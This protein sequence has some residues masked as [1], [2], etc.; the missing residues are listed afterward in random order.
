M[1]SRVG[2]IQSNLRSSCLAQTWMSRTTRTDCHTLATSPSCCLPKG[3]VEK[4]LHCTRLQ[5][6]S[7]H[8][9]RRFACLRRV[10]ATMPD[11]PNRNRCFKAVEVIRT[12]GLR[13]SLVPRARVG[14]RLEVISTWNTCRLVQAIGLLA[15]S[16]RDY[17]MP[18]CWGTMKSFR[19]EVCGRFG[20]TSRGRLCGTGM[21]TIKVTV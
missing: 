2:R 10:V 3:H 20:W 21:I 17:G 6:S 15:I 4:A 14:L 1:V 13:S 11:Q 12:I 19:I 18:H 5:P 16:L 7:C 8:S 9:W